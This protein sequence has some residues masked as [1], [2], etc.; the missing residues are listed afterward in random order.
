MNIAQ[1]LG[2]LAAALL[3]RK[4]GGTLTW[5]SVEEWL[6]DHARRDNY[7][8]GYAGN[9]LLSGSSNS[10]VE[11]RKEPRNGGV[12]VIASVYLDPRQGATACK[13]WE[14]SKL[15]A[16]LEKRFGNNYRF[17]IDI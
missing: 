3:M 7:G 16:Q 15:D 11:L 4:T 6:H 8:S 17:R 2:A 13:T 5:K 14:T 12:R 10:Y 9:A 1:G